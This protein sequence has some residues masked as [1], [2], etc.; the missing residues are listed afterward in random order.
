MGCV[1]SGVLGHN[2]G[3]NGEGSRDSSGKYHGLPINLLEKKM[4]Q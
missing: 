1:D 4:K 3:M 2:Y